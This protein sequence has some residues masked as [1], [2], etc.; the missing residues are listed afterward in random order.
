MSFK[1]KKLTLNSENGWDS[2][3]VEWSD[4]LNDVVNAFPAGGIII[5]EDGNEYMVM[6]QYTGDTSAEDI[7]EQEVKLSLYTQVGII[8]S[9]KYFQFSLSFSGVMPS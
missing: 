4:A 3:D 6:G 5:G 9:R 8:C 7:N 2:T 1:Y